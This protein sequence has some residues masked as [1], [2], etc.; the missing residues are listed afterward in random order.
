MHVI[1]ERQV[2]VRVRVGRWS[3]VVRP[4]VRE[5]GTAARPVSR[6]KVKVKVWV[7]VVA[8]VGPWGR[9]A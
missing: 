7:V 4:G 5:W 8:L 9:Q 6:V 2:E 3:T 1:S